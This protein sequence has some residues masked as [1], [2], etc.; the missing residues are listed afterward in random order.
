MS[1]GG[2]PVGQILSEARR[3][4]SPPIL[5]RPFGEA[6]GAGLVSEKI[7]DFRS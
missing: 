5:D 1:D 3:D 2:S 6:D 4:Y 7:V